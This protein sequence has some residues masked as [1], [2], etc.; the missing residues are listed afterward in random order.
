MRGKSGPHRAGCKLTACGGDSRESATENYRLFIQVRLKRRGK[1]S[2]IPLVTRGWCKPHPEQHL[3][4]RISLP[5]ISREGGW[6][7][8]AT[9]IQDR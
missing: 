2:P 1:S 7:C 9:H 5:D 8:V 3:T 4:G 6:K